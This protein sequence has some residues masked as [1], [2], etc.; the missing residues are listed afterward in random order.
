VFLRDGF[1]DRY[2]GDK[3]LFPGIF[4]ILKLELP[5]A[6]PYYLKWKM[7]ETHIVYWELFPTIDHIF[8]IARGGQDLSMLRNSAIS[9]WTLEEMGWPLK[10]W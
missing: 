10:D 5:H 6:F 8:P 4:R 3:L 2:A 9:N 7:N 1:I